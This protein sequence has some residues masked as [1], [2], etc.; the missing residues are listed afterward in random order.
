MAKRWISAAVAAAMLA[1][2][3]G[4]SAQQTSDQQCP[5]EQQDQNG[6]CGALPPG[7]EGGL[8]ALGV[9]TPYVVGALAVGTIILIVV[10]TGGG[11]GGGTTTTTVTTR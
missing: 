8:A 1:S 7:P 2:T 10:A 9:A 3:V 5:R 11:G 6:K 4:A